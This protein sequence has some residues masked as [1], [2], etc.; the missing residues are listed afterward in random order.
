MGFIEHDHVVQALAAYGT[1]ET[2]HV[3]RLPRTC[4]AIKVSAL[5]VITIQGAQS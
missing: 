5:A 3:R 2:L 1:H 4:R